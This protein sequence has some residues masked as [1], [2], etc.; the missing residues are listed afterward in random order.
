MKWLLVTGGGHGIGQEIA[1]QASRSGYAVAIWDRDGDA[2]RAVADELTTPTQVTELDITD[3][4][5]VLAAVDALPAVP[6]ALV[7]NAGTVRFGPLVDL[8]LE[9]WDRAIRVNLTGSFIV[10]RAV[11]R[12]M[13]DRG[14]GCVVNISS[15]NGVAAAPMV[16]SYSAAKAGL[17]MLTQ[18]MALEWAGY[19]LRVNAV[20]PGL[21]DA[22]MSEPIYADPD[23]RQQRTSRVPLRRLGRPDDIAAAVMYLVSDAASYLTGQTIVVDGGITAATLGSLSRPASVDGVGI[24]PRAPQ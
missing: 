21:I 15:I 19:G 13:I 22:G 17:L 4:V 16:G 9:D 18:Q 14:S 20:A 1:R 5:A 24:R 10:G 11:A 7:N 12:T 8:S 23:V 6:D 2:A 3:E